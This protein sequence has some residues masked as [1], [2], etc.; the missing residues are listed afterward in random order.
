MAAHVAF[1]SETE[2]QKL[3]EIRRAERER[4]LKQVHIIVYF[5]SNRQ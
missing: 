3:K 1:E 4:I 2:K 5:D